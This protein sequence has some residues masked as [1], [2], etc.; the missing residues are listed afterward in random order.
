MKVDVNKVSSIL[1]I[2]KICLDKTVES[3]L[4]NF[5]ENKLNTQTVLT[6]HQLEKLFELPSL[7][8]TTLSH[9]EHYFATIAD[10][11]NFLELDFFRVLKILRSSELLITSEIEVYDAANKWLNY[12]I[13][14]RRKFAKKLLLTVR[15]PLLSDGTLNYLLDRSSSF[16]EMKD[17]YKLLQEISEKKG[18]VFHNNSSIYYKTRYCNQQ[19]FDILVCGGRDRKDISVSNIKQVDVNNFNVNVLPS[20]I[21][22]RYVFEVVCVNGAIYVFGGI[23]DGYNWINSVEKYSPSTMTWNKVA[24]MYDDRMG[25]CVCAFMDK[26]FVIGGNFF[27]TASDSCLQFNTKDYSWKEVAGMKEAR[28]MAACAVFEE[29]IVV[30]GGHGMN[31]SY[32]NSVKSYDVA[33]DTWTPMPDMIERRVGHSSVVVK[34][35][36]FVLGGVLMDGNYE[37]F[38]SVSNKF[39]LLESS[40]PFSSNNALSIGTKIYIL[41]KN[42]PVVVIYDVDKDEWSWVES[43]ATKNIDEFSCAK[44]PV[45]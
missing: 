43:E 25:H 34:N 6:F 35:K 36:L 42:H 13:E 17:C 8:K 30:S 10:T 24:D 18:V 4:S 14:K 32:L 21:E 27:G 22:K 5:I 12:N 26:I 39:V 40:I 45:Y 3:K 1:K 28:K 29:R 19:M 15:F 16:I 37:V 2:N 9:I 7:L 38:E 44:L 11:E 33:A 23:G 20:M 31:T 41:L